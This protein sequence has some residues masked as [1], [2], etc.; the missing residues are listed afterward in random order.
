MA[1]TRPL[2]YDSIT[3]AAAGGASPETYDKHLVE[4]ATVTLEPTTSMID[5]G[6]TLTDFYDVTFEVGLYEA[7]VLADARVYSNGSSEP[8][9]A[10]ISFNRATGGTTL[11][12]ESVIINGKRDFSGNRVQVVLNGSKRAVS[13]DDSVDVAVA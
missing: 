10:D 11:K 12:L 5:D 1:I 4:S 9:K 3:I 2:I 7:S 13:I 6:Q 8:V